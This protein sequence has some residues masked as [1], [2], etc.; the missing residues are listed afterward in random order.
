M[1]RGVTSFK[2]QMITK[3]DNN[4]FDIIIQS[5]G[6][7]FPGDL[8]T[9]YSINLLLMHVNTWNPVC[10][11]YVLLVGQASDKI[12]VEKNN[13]CLILSK[14]NRV[15]T[16]VT[17]LESENVVKIDVNIH[18]FLLREHSKINRFSLLNK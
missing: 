11:H 5:Y 17:P 12:Q 10:I 6:C 2:L 15:I 14:K 13:L 18:S 9:S 3:Y 8:V 4:L 7:F 16:D 1:Q